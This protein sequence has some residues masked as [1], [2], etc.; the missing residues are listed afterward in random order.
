[1]DNYNGSAGMYSVG[2]IYMYLH[3]TSQAED[4]VVGRLGL[5][6]LQCGLNGVVLL[7]EQVIGP[8]RQMA[9]AHLSDKLHPSYV[10]CWLFSTFSFHRGVRT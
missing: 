5:E 3:S 2:Y 8:V 10:S 7:G 9:L 6:A 1:M 4:T